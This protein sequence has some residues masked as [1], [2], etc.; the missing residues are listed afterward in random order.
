M[1]GII[2]YIMGSNSQIA[3]T[4]IRIG[5]RGLA[6][7]A[8]LNHPNVGTHFG[9]THDAIELVESGAVEPEVV[10]QR[11]VEAPRAAGIWLGLAAQAAL[12]RGDTFGV[13]R[14]LREAYER[15]GP[16]FPPDLS[17]MRIREEVGF[18]IADDGWKVMLTSPAGGG[19]TPS[20]TP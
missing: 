2:L 15:S 8:A 19:G 9:T 4:L 5:A 10:A 11:A 1:R 6:P 18:L 7:L 16:S 12:A 17:A 14:Y 13:V 20:T 3:S